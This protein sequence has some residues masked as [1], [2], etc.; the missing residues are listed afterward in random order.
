M[1]RREVLRRSGRRAGPALVALGV[2]VAAAGCSSS[3]PVASPG[4]TTGSGPAPGSSAPGTT[5]PVRWTATVTGEDEINPGLRQGLARV[6]QQ[7][8]FSTN[9]G[10]YRT[11]AAYRPTAPPGDRAEPAIPAELAAE[12]YDH[13]GDIDV[14][15]GV[16]WA[17]LETPDKTSGRQVLARYTESS[18]TYQDH[19]TVPQHHAS[20]VTVDSEGIIWSADEFDLVEALLRY[21]LE[22]G[23]L[24]QL[25]PLVFERPIE[26]VQGVDVLDGAAWV[27][28]D[29]D[30][31]GVY[32]VDLATGAVTDL[33][34]MGHADGEGEGIDARPGP[35]GTV[36]LETVSA[37]AAA[38]PMRIVHLV[39]RPTAG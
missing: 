32:R 15:D 31:D 21:R 28:T 16:V 7:W 6:G 11:D 26:R 5:R 34:S 29:D 3:G 23:R 4:S 14:V 12:G 20:F 30:H 27:S 9:N 13:V 36:L 35:D 1:L 38:V 39:A 33:G 25:P 37:D 8:L 18:L 22:N 24:Q 19:F 2:L 17:P 10:I